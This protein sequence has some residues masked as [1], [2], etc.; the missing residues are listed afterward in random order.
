MTRD[1]QIRK[2]P[3]DFRGLCGV[4]E[5]KRVAVCQVS[6]SEARVANVFEILRH[7]FGGSDPKSYL[8]D[9]GFRQF[10]LCSVDEAKLTKYPPL[11]K[12]L[13]S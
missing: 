8:S 13:Q 10:Y 11:S 7:L 4:R 1:I 5:C 2:M 12:W 3:T 9:E 6:V